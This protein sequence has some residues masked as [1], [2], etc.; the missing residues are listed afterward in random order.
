[1]KSPKAVLLPPPMLRY[2]S[3][4]PPLTYARVNRLHMLSNPA[5][6]ERLFPWL[7]DRLSV[8]IRWME[9]FGTQPWLEFTL[10]LRFSY[11]RGEDLFS[12]QLHSVRGGFRLTGEMSPD[13]GL[14]LMADQLVLMMITE[15]RWRNEQILKEYRRLRGTN[16]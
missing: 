6:W 3:D 10:V 16:P 7:R 5:D 8:H 13:D 11:R 15:M 4:L 12:T 1:M 14:L 2:R 9:D